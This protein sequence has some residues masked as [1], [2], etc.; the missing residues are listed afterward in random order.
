MSTTTFILLR[1]LDQPIEILPPT[2]GAGPDLLRLSAVSADGL[3]EKFKDADLIYSIDLPS[4]YKI[5]P[6]DWRPLIDDHDALMNLL[7]ETIHHNLAL[8]RFEP[9]TDSLLRRAEAMVRLAL[10]DLARALDLKTVT[11]RMDD[12]G[13]LWVSITYDRKN[14]SHRQLDYKDA[15]FLRE[16]PR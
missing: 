8:L 10:A 1:R 14:G 9:V 13:L 3:L 7:G 15:R 2:I 11:C 4:G 12:L 5:R 16:S 6:A